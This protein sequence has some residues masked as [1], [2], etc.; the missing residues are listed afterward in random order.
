MA[1]GIST[2]TTHPSSTTTHPP[3][4]TTRPPT[5]TTRPATTT[6]R[7]PTTTTRPPTT[8]TRPPT[9]TTRPATTTTRPATTTTRPATTTTRPPTT[10]TRPATTTTRPATTTTR[11]AT[12][13]THPATTTT[14]PGTTTTRPGTTTTRPATT[15]TRPVTTTTHP[16]TTTTHPGT[17][18]TQ[19]ATT[20]HPGTTT[21]APA[22]TTTAA[23]SGTTTAPGGTTTAAPGGTT[24]AAPGGT[25]TAAPGGTTTAAPGG[26]TT[27]APGS[28]TTAGSGPAIDSFSVA[29]A[30]DDGLKHPSD[31]VQIESGKAVVLSWTIRNADGV[32]LADPASNTKSFDSGTTSTNLTPDGDGGD[33]TL[34]A[35][36]GDARSAPKTVH[37]ATHEAGHVYSPH[38]TLLH[39]GDPA[40]ID[41]FTVG[42]KGSKRGDAQATLEAKKDATVTLFWEVAGDIHAIAIDNGVGDVTGKTDANFDA[43]GGQGQADVAFSPD[44]SGAVTFTLT[45]TPTDKSAQPLT[46]TVK[47]TR[48]GSGIV[49]TPVYADRLKPDLDATW[50]LYQRFG[51]LDQAAQKSASAAGTT[52]DGSGDDGVK[53]KVDAYKKKLADNLS[54]AHQQHPAEVTAD[55][56]ARR[57]QRALQAAVEAFKLKAQAMGEKSNAFLDARAEYAGRA[58]EEKYAE[59]DIWAA[60]HAADQP[61]LGLNFSFWDVV[62]GLAEAAGLAAITAFT[63]GGNL[64]AAAGAAVV[65]GVVDQAKGMAMGAGQQALDLAK[66]DITGA[67]SKSAEAAKNLADLRQKLQQAQGKLQD[68]ADK[69]SHAT[70]ELADANDQYKDA[71]G[72]LQP[73][74]QAY[75]DALQKLAD[76]GGGD[77]SLDDLFAMY[78]DLDA[79]EAVG[80][81]LLSQMDGRVGTKAANIDS[82]IHT[83]SDAQ[84][85]STAPRS[86]DFAGGVVDGDRKV[87]SGVGTLDEVHALGDELSKLK[88]FRA[89]RANQKS[90]F[91][92]WQA[93]LDPGSQLQPSVTTTAAGPDLPPITPGHT[94]SLI[95][96]PV[97]ADRLRPDLD[98][99]WPLLQKWRGLD[100]A[101]QASAADA[102]T[103]ID[104]ATDG[105]IVSAVN[106]FK[107]NLQANIAKAQRDD[108]GAVTIDNEVRRARIEFK[109]ATATAGEKYAQF[110]TAANAFLDSKSAFQQAAGA[111]RLDQGTI[112]AEQQGKDLDSLG[113]HLDLWG[114]VKAIGENVGKALLNIVTSGGNVMSALTQTAINSVVD[115]AKAMGDQVKGKVLD[116]AKAQITGDQQAAS[117]A[118]DASQELKDKLAQDQGKL[119]QQA[120]ALSDATDAM[121]QALT[122]YKDALAALEPKRADYADALAQLAKAGGGGAADVKIGGLLAMYAQLQQR[123]ATGDQLEPAMNGRVGTAAKNIDFLIHRFLDV[124]S[125]ATAPRGKGFVGGI[126]DDDPF[127]YQG[128]DTLREVQLFGEELKELKAWREARPAQKQQLSAWKP[129]LD[130]L[131]GERPDN[132]PQPQPQPAS[133]TTAHVVTPGH[134]DDMVRVPIDVSLVRADLDATWPLFQQWKGLDQAAQTAAKAGGV[135]L[136]GAGD[137]AVGK[138]VDAFKNAPKR[139]DNPAVVSVADRAREAAG[140]YQAVAKKAQGKLDD[141]NKKAQAFFKA[142]SDYNAGAAAVAQDQGAIDAQNQQQD[143]PSLGIKFDLWETVKGLGKAA[144]DAAM[145]ALKSGGNVLTASVSAVEQSALDTAKNMGTTAGTSLL[146]MAKDDIFGAQTQS[147]GASDALAKLQGKLAEDQ[148]KLKTQT[149]ALKRAATSLAKAAQAFKDAAEAM[150]PKRAV[151]QDALAQLAKAGGKK[152]GKVQM[153]G[154]LAMFGCLSERESLGG[155]LQ[156]AIDAR[157]ATQAANIDLLAHKFADVQ[158]DSSAPRLR[159]QACG[160]VDSDRYVYRGADTLDEV[161]AIGAKLRALQAWRAG[162]DGQK[163]QLTDWQSALDGVV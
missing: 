30:D 135:A 147:Q 128:C 25:T 97:Y 119:K 45:V 2:T 16:V 163:Q 68:A 138:A 116:A 13:T 79:R 12:T 91:A 33:Y 20:T 46:Q 78:A 47:V 93:M 127:I 9:T 86:K 123:E 100:K 132:P 131:A 110:N 148:G 94:R 72:E 22:G 145:E 35:K 42:E 96:T 66:D 92:A 143:L 122:A 118:V 82:L 89:A 153:D 113:I 108:P 29:P 50:P 73:R 15:T 44:S 34:T 67:Q 6:T 38:L 3:A 111:V 154:I 11:P 63:G 140:D 139:K 103:T 151:Y 59:G 162:R 27:A 31:S 156:S 5:T 150:E 160:I 137:A 117:A 55:L 114:A 57:A 161:A 102:G 155:E 10:T 8:T 88:A 87:F 141:L 81:V 74:H 53:S 54:K 109:A 146:G 26:T 121:T 52:L 32:D 80:E 120:I 95:A 126:V 64:I 17:T 21:T 56:D 39:N 124:Q 41:T 7:L 104:G 152:P 129:L 19:V 23:P 62:K 14:R 107:A 69:L 77:S 37:V 158:S 58:A 70:D 65:A 4:T 71:L 125:D 142:Q 40:A 115:Q 36:S 61:T 75:S 157:T 136:D 83:F 1:G 144:G 28:T 105:D 85:D 101:A 24:T 99:T 49:A 43:G 76:A 60:E 18:T 130:D 112:E 98:A 133:T 149:T 134:S 48:A 90:Q 51:E 106:T 159:G 84:P